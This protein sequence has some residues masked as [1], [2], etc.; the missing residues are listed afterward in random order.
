MK[1]YTI[2]FGRVFR[3]AHLVANFRNDQNQFIKLRLGGG[4]NG[5]EV[6]MFRKNVPDMTRDSYF[7]GDLMEAH[8]V[9]LRE[10]YALARPNRDNN[11][12]LVVIKTRNEW[13]SRRAT[14]TWCFDPNTTPSFKVVDQILAR[15]TGP[16]DYFRNQR[17]FDNIGWNDALVVMNVGDAVRITDQ[18]GR[19]TVVM[20][21][22]VDKGLVKL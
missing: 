12:I 16:V 15:A 1:V 13:N 6:P 19:L 22:S 7:G 17:D 10:G 5:V 9:R 18:S 4:V 20:Y 2:E 11:Q 21:E 8:P 3:G 14:G